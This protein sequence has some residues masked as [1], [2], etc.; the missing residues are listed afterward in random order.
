MRLHVLVAVSCLLIC[1]ATPLPRQASV[2]SLPSFTT[3]AGRCSSV[4]DVLQCLEVLPGSEVSHRHFRQSLGFFIQ[5]HDSFGPGRH[6]H[7]SPVN[8]SEPLS[9]ALHCLDAWYAAQ[10]HNPAFCSYL[11]DETQP[12]AF[13]NT[14]VA[15]QQHF[16]AA[17][18]KDNEAVM[19]HFIYQLMQL[20]LAAPTPTTYFVSVYESG[21][22]DKTGTHQANLSRQHCHYSPV[23]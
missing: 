21:S 5:A 4:E 23:A 9:Q 15:K 18:M 3:P 12:S 10:H 7:R 20:V 2:Y 16:V 14:A 8:P 1:Q 19:P 22:R 6:L 17:N 13:N 11:A